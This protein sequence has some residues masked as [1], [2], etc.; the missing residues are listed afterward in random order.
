MFMCVHEEVADSGCPS[1]DGGDF[2][3]MV[4]FLTSVPAKASLLHSQV[5]DVIF[6]LVWYGLFIVGYIINIR[7]N[8]LHHSY[9]NFH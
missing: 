4:W 8:M 7:Y 5:R 6:V 2:L 9:S 3:H 1:S